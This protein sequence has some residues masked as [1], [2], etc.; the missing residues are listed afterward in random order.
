MK[1]IVMLGDGMADLPIAELHGKTPLMVA[2]KPNMD[3]LAQH[4][5]VGMTKHFVDNLPMGS[6]VANLSVMGYDP[7]VYYTGRSPLEAVSL[8]I[9]MEP[10]DVAMRCN[11]VTL[12]DEPEYEDKTM[13]DY[14]SDEITTEEARE[15]VNYLGQFF[16][17]D[18]LHLYPGISYRECLVFKHAELGTDCIPPHDLTGKPIR[19]HLPKGTYGTL[20]ADMMRR[21][22][23][24]LR[25]HPVNKAREAR[26]LRP[27]N[28]CWFWGEGTRPALDSFQSLYG[29]KGSVVCGVDLIRGIGLCAGMHAPYIEGATG[30]KVT[31]FAAKGRAAL[32]FLREGSDMVYVHVEAPD[33][34]GHAGDAKCKVWTIESIDKEI[35]GPLMEGLR[36]DG[37]DFAVLLTPDHPTP[38]PVRTHTPD[39]IPFVLYTSRRNAGPSALAYDEESAKATGLFVAHGPS[40]MKKLISEDF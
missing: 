1:Y 4:G 29:V 2:K 7:R 34:S 22:Y 18:A 16:N 38:V 23:D 36:A 24:L 28:S 11:L 9:D 13:V 27:A 31:D 37:E 12:S 35:L 39:A 40:L 30:A 33:E 5:A 32:K 14:S 26:G 20:C 19:G 25:N 17:T 6:D 21:S 10:D 15:L 8:H 3:Y